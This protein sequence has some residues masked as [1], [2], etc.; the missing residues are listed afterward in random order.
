LLRHFGKPGKIF[1]AM[2]LAGGRPGGPAAPATRGPYE[3]VGQKECGSFLPSKQGPN[4]FL[5]CSMGDVV[6]PR[7]E[8][9]Q[10]NCSRRRQ[11]SVGVFS[12]RKQLVAE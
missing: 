12:G 9:I 6:E 5:L 4:T 2:D 8:F 3:E 11:Q 10:D 7:R 1:H